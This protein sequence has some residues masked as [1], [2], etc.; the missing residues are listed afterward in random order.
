MFGTKKKDPEPETT[1]IEDQTIASSQEGVPLPVIIGRRSVKVI[2]ISNVYNHK[3]RPAPTS[4]PGK[5]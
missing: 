5:K 3:P 1:A 2:W 4:R